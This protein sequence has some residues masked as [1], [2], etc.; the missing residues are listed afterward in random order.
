MPYIDQDAINWLNAEM[1]GKVA[2]DLGIRYNECF[3]T[4]ESM[5]PAVVHA[6]GEKRWMYNLEER[7]RGK[8]WQEYE[9]YC[10]EPKRKCREAGIRF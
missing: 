6:A 3:V 1:G 4:G 7:Y 5:R 10:E 8:Y 2:L 9:Q